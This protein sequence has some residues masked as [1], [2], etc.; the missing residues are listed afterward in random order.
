MALYYSQNLKGPKAL[1]PL[2]QN[3]NLRP[4][5]PSPNPHNLLLKKEPH[6]SL[7]I[8]RLAR[9]PILHD[10]SAKSQKPEAPAD[11]DHLTVK[12]HH[13]VVAAGPGSP[14]CRCKSCR[15]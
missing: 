12:G 1:G 6:R 2:T 3:S 8:L 7:K 15:K 13:L 5:N 9:L 4:Q 11:A 10:C 14:V